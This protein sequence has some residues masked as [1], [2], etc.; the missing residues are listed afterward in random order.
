MSIDLGPGFWSGMDQEF[1]SAASRKAADQLAAQV[2]ALAE[3]IS[4]TRFEWID[5]TAIPRRQHVYGTHYTRKFISSTLSTGGTGKSRLVLCEALAMVSGKPLLNVTPVGQLRVAY[6][7]GEDPYE[8][9]QRIVM[10]TVLHYGLD[11]ADFEGRLFVDSGRVMPIS[12]AHTTREGT[13]VAVPIVDALKEKLR[14]NQI[15][16][17]IVDPFVSSHHVNENDNMAVNMVAKT[18]ANIAD[19]LSIA[20]ELV[21]H[22]RKSNGSELT[23][24]DGR[25]ASALLAAARSAR[26]L[27]TMSSSEAAKADVT[28]QRRTYFR[29]DNGKLNFAPPPDGSRWYRIID[30]ELGEFE[31]IEHVGVV[32]NWKYPDLTLDVRSEDILRAQRAIA[33]RPDGKEWRKDRRATNWVG[34]PIAEAL[35]LDLANAQHEEIVKRLIK[36]WV[37]VGLL[38]E[39]TTREDSKERAVIRVGKAP[40]TSAAQTPPDPAKPL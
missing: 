37:K 2:K 4:L 30:F 23:V 1:R 24:E 12:I 6:W 16:V 36:D 18:W 3:K 27:N 8:E 34:R 29:E 26:V 32:T 19:E 5:P 21:H 7:N 38:V 35:G 40:L 15:D 9:L 39:G 33:E 13:M 22:T 11:R 31:M 10:A 20:I 28:E 17:L 14:E 25:G